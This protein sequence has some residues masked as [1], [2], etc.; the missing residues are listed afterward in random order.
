MPGCVSAKFREGA[1]SL[2]GGG[3]S[4]PDG[5]IVAR[6]PVTALTKAAGGFR[7]RLPLRAVEQRQERVDV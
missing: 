2:V 1:I 6:Q 4:I 5:R 7:L 3:W